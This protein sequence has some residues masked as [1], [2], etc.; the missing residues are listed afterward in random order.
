MFVLILFLK[1]V[2]GLYQADCM[3]SFGVH[4]YS[5]YVVIFRFFFYFLFKVVLESWDELIKFGGA[6][7]F[8]GCCIDL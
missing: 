4:Y 1:D 8:Q 3:S 2:D 6:F 7:V 5:G